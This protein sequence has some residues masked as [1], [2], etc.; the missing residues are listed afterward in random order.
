MRTKVI[1]IA[2]PVALVLLTPVAFF[3]VWIFVA[4]GSDTGSPELAAEWRNELLE[5]QTYTAAIEADATIE[6]VTFENGEWLIGRA[7]D[8]HGMWRRGGGTLVIRD[9][10]D[11][12]H[13]FFGHVCGPDYIS[14]GFGKHDNLKSFY[15][16]VKESGFEEYAFPETY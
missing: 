6:H 14:W 2:T 10:N 15:G 9:C 7:Q 8:S 16:S 11:E 5:Y 12:T 13:V 4:Y 3:A 1:L